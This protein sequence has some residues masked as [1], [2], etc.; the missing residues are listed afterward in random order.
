[1]DRILA[2][3]PAFNEQET[4][5][6]LLAELSRAKEQLPFDILVINDASTDE[7]G[8]LARRSEMA[9]VIDLP[10]NLGVGGAVQ[11]G[12][13]YALKNDYDV[14]FQFDADG[15]HRT[16]E[17]VSLLD[18]IRKGEA[19]VVIGSRFL[20]RHAGYRSTWGRRVGIQ[21]LKFMTRFL[22]HQAITDCTSGFRAYN[23]SATEFLAEH[24]PVDYP[25]PEAVILLGKNGFQMKEVFTPMNERMG[26]RSSITF[27]RG[28]YYMVK[29]M[30]SIIMVATRRKAL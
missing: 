25:E 30:L 5:S 16:D 27:F 28:P 8:E 14:V 17:I 10:C 15:Q 22:I 24:Y 3:I 1:M 21:L 12:F 4:I 18:P 20:E 2:I 26:G 23:R 7:T 29:V 19:D 9:R 13:F 6:G 11:T